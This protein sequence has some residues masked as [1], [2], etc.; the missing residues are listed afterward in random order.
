MKIV[1]NEIE[2]VTTFGQIKVG[3]ICKVNTDYFMKL[4]VFRDKD[5]GLYNCFSFTKN[6]FHYFYS[7]GRVISCPN[8]TLVINY[9][10][11]NVKRS[12]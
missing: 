5:G 6:Y 12:D 8:A 2:N 1:E 9:N 3:D 7:E 11:K 4:P 10:E